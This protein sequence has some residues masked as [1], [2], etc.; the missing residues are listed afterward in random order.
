MAP[1][2]PEKKL[3]VLRTPRRRRRW[4][5]WGAGASL[6]TLAVITV[7][8]TI[9]AHHVE[10]FLHAQIVQGLQQRFHTRVELDHFDVAVHHGQQAQWGVWATGRGLRIWPPHQTGGDRQLEVQP[11]SLPLIQ[12]G[13]FSFHVPLRLATAK[14][15]RIA[16][17]RLRELQIHV[18]PRSQRRQGP[19]NTSGTSPAPGAGSSGDAGFLSKITVARVDCQR[20]LLVLETDKPGKLPMEFDIAH[21]TLKGVT[22]GG[23]MAFDATLT[24]PKPEGLIHS[25]GHFGPWNTADPGESPV[26]G[27]YQFSHADLA[28]FKGIAGLLASTGNYRGTLRNIL[29]NG[30][31]DVPDFQLTHFG[32]PMPLHTHF[33]AHV[34]GTDGDTWLD[35]V[36][37][38]LGHSHFTTQGQIVRIKLPADS[39]G[40][41]A[42]PQEEQPQETE[43]GHLIDLKVDVAHARIEDFLRLA[44]RS[45]PPILTGDVSAKAVLHIPPGSQPI[46]TRIKLDG[47]FKLDQAHFTGESIQKKVEELSLRGQGRPGDAKSADANSVSSQMQGSFHMAKGVIALPDLQY[48]VPGADIHLSG[49]YALDGPLSFDGTARMKATV[50]QIVGGW[51]GFLLKPVDRLFKKDGA[52]ALIPIKVRGTRDSPQFGLDFGRIGKSSPE[53]PGAERP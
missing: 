23:A 33:T 11:Q 21:L 34:D 43:A 4:W 50:S 14:S 35:S 20:A 31:A 47:T 19:E 36:D 17:V 26:D 40:R 5:A 52:G 8:L 48:D 13:E 7:V 3:E 44:S 53:T 15:L 30:D 22:S 2:Q 39:R 46:H 25:T 16:E 42:A 49:H 29:V 28:T 9:L 51:K 24:N 10:P 6:A 27:A 12:L 37:A 32:N 1:G 45:S 41:S 38:T 18:P